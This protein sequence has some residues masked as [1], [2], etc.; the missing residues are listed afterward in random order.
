MKSLNAASNSSVQQPEGDYL[1]PEEQQAWREKLGNEPLQKGEGESEAVHQ[2]KSFLSQREL[3]NLPD[4][5]DFE[6]LT[7][8]AV[9]GAQMRRGLPQTGVFDVQTRETLLTGPKR[10]PLRLTPAEKELWNEALGEKTLKRGKND[11]THVKHLQ[12]FLNERELESLV[13]DGDFGGQTEQAVKA[14]QLR[15]G[16]EPSG[17]FDQQTRSK[18]L[19]A[20]KNIVDKG[21]SHEIVK[22]RI[23]EIL[24]AEHHRFGGQTVAESGSVTKRGHR[25]YESGYDKRIGDYWKSIGLNFDGDDRSVPWSAAFI[26]FA[27]RMAGAGEQFKAG[28][29]HASYIRDSIMA[30][31][32]GRTDAAYLGH[33]SSERAPQVGDLIGRAR[34]G[35][36]NYEN[37][38]SSYKSHTDLVVEVGPGFVKMIG[39]NVADSVSL[40]TLG[41]DSKGFLNNQSR[42]FVV[43]EPNNLAGDEHQES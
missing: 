21:A 36:V 25:E 39:G 15:H 6:V 28:P 11:E 40:T 26:S 31:K 35:G 38:P 16:L 27:H 33:R 42:Y 10:D 18:L 37:Q 41:T 13:V 22:A 14:A 29:A 34:Q 43:M 20:T 2:L 32:E 8:N 1:S 23:Q 7:E 5:G 4:D 9:K 24:R 12:A 19:D 3:I 30:K 17:I